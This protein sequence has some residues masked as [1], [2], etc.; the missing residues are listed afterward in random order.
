MKKRLKLIL[1][2]AIFCV[3]NSIAFG[4]TTLN[5]TFFG[6]WTT[7]GSKVRTVIFMD[8]DDVF[9]MVKWDSSD[10]EELEVVKLQVINNSIKTTVKV[11]S[12]NW[13]TYNTYSI[14]NENTLKCVV[15]G[16]AASG[17]VIYLKRLK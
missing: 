7:D 12:T 6:Y 3:A 9:Q 16:D 4:Q 8:K 13:V 11:I 5:K 15:G 1:L 14:V 2:T 17:T 10:G